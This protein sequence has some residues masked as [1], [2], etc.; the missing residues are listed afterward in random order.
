[1]TLTRANANG[2]LDTAVD[3]ALWTAL[4]PAAGRGT[5]LGFDQPKILFPIAGKT[6]LEWLV[7]LLRPLCSRFVFVLS[8]SGREPVEHLAS[9]LLH[10]RYHI[11]VQKEPRGMADAVQRGLETLL[12][13]P[14]A[15]RGP[16]P[17]WDRSPACPLETLHTLIVWGDQVA[18]RPESLEFA[19]R[20]HQGPAQPSATCPTLLRDN[21]YIHFERDNAG[22]VTQVLQARE[23]DSLPPHGESD[24]GVFLFRTDALRQLLPRL[25]TSGECIGNKTRELNFLPIFAMIDDLITLPIMTE[26]ESVGVN[27]AAD[28][29]YL[30]RHLAGA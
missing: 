17:Q 21:P 10:G 11:A 2:F 16:T 5:R 6:I 12:I 4:I 29:E 8:P 25:L 26:T 1:L 20:V 7:E 3:P 28:A 24:S 30:A 23:G 18:L 27:S 9:T 19:M 22:R 15:G 13:E 14:R